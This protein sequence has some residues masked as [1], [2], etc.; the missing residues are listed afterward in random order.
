MNDFSNAGDAAA[1]ADIFGFPLSV[2]LLLAHY[3]RL[4]F[5]VLGGG[6]AARGRREI[7]AHN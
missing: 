4:F 6:M 5:V 2:P 1:A 7:D 3:T